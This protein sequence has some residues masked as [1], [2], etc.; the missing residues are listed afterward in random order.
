MASVAGGLGL[1]LASL[2]FPKESPSPEEM[3]AAEERSIA[4]QKRNT[5]ETLVQTIAIAA[6]QCRTVIGNG[7]KPKPARQK[8]SRV[9]YQE[10]FPQVGSSIWC[11]AH[12]T[13]SRKKG[14]FPMSLQEQGFDYVQRRDGESILA[15][16]VNAATF[17]GLT[18]TIPDS[19]L[20]GNQSDCTAHDG[21]RVSTYVSVSKTFNGTSAL[22]QNELTTSALFNPRGEAYMSPTVSMRYTDSNDDGNDQAGN[23]ENMCEQKSRFCVSFARQVN[24]ILK[25]I[26]EMSKGLQ[27]S[28][29]NTSLGRLP[30]A[31]PMIPAS[32]KRSTMR[33][34]RE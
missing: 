31:G 34:A 20:C 26:V 16:S 3:Q 9:A 15:F 33:A 21:T 28:R 7:T 11:T 1:L 19:R 25:S 32:S 18:Y 27:S 6:E 8:H 24:G 13:H 30:W 29:T 17:L 2:Y 12:E 10:D 22:I 23:G 14:K 4:D 5:L